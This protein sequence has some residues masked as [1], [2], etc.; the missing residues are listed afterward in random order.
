MSEELVI[1]NLK[2]TSIA[3]QYH[4][5]C[6]PIHP[7]R[8]RQLV[9]LFKLQPQAKVLDMGCGKGQLLL[10]ICEA[11]QCQGLGVDFCESFIKDAR[12]RSKESQ[13]EE[14]VQFQQMDGRLFKSK[15]NQYDLAICLGAENIFGGYRNALKTF[16][17]WVKPGGQI[18][19]LEGIWKT[20]PEDGYLQLLGIDPAEFEMQT[21][22]DTVKIGEAEDL[23]LA[24]SLVS[25]EAEFDHYEGLY[26]LG[27]EKYALE[28]PDDP[29]IEEFLMRIRRWKSGYF[30][31]GR[32]A[33]ACGIYLFYKPLNG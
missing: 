18:L 26:W 5:F 25:T 29:D 12:R 24:Y 17:T 4:D 19:I 7:Q 1:P 21:H 9:E 2:F 33:L 22:A 3:H 28:N 31:W 32:Q 13:L 16:K 6:N 23:A 30:K 11:Y 14:R 20:R 8:V 27:I 15:E 10:D